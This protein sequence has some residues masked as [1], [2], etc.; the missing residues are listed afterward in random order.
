MSPNQRRPLPFS[1]QRQPATMQ[2]LHSRWRGICGQVGNLGNPFFSCC[3]TGGCWLNHGVLGRCDT[4][5]ASMHI[6]IRSFAH[7]EPTAPFFP[8]FFFWPWDR[9]FS[10]CSLPRL[11]Q[12]RDRFFVADDDASADVAPAAARPPPPTKQTRLAPGASWTKN[13]QHEEPRRRDEGT[14]LF[15]IMSALYRQ[16]QVREPSSSSPGMTHH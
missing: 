12:A 7:P 13:L 8:L 2:G 3:R 10:S 1:L 4:N 15:N 16:G 9:P 14:G 6:G 5:E 11:G